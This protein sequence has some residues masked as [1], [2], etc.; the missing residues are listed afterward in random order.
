MLEPAEVVCLAALGAVA[1]LEAAVRL[2]DL[3]LGQPGQKLQGVDVLGVDS[4]QEPLLVQQAEELV[5]GG[6]GQGGREQLPDQTI[7]RTGVFSE[8]TSFKHCFRI[9]QIIFPQL[10]VQA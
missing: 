9:W 7:E 5:G 3:V 4:A 1:P 8:I 2:H 6:G 10:E